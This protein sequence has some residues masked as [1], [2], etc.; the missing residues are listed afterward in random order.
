MIAEHNGKVY[1][2]ETMSE[3]MTKTEMAEQI[4]NLKNDLNQGF[5]IAILKNNK[6]LI[7]EMDK[8][9]AGKWVEAAI[10]HASDQREE[11]TY[12]W[13]KRISDILFKIAVAVGGVILTYHS[14][15]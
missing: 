12:D 3:L 10:R 1:S 15:S 8:K 2:P 14:F 9:F 6:V 13:L 11:R 4:K 5:E 7:D